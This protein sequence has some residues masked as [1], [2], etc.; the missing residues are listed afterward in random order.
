MTTVIKVRVPGS[1]SNCGAGFD[2]LGLGLQIYNTVTLKLTAEGG[3]Q[4]ARAS[5]ARA[6]EMVDLV[7]R[8]FAAAG[9]AVPAGFIYRIDGDVPVSRGLGSSITVLAG[10]LGGLN[11]A[12]GQPLSAVDQ[13]KI[14]TAI[15]GH[16]DNATAG[17]WGGFCVAR[18]G[19]T[20]ADYVDVVRIE[21]PETL[22]FVV[23]FPQT[24]IATNGSRKVLPTE[25]SHADAVRSV[26]S[27]AYLTAAMASGDF[28]KLRGAAEDFLHEPYRL[29]GIAGAAPAIQAGLQAGALTGWLS[30]S[31]S[32]VLCVADDSQ[33]QAVGAAMQQA[34]AAAAGEATVRVL[35]ADNRG[36][37]IQSE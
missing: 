11:T 19:A 14:L 15:E 25:I 16:P 23:V 33:A 26:N 36:I 17:F 20:A 5:D 30:G 31:G 37:V 27:A 7:C 34:F 35:A 24:E 32:S 18:C 21:I 12:S 10:I 1:T 6:A 4:P 8:K 3:A 2:T 29:P 9:H 22:K 13:V 28:A